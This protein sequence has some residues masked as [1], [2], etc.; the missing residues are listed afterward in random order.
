MQG[1]FESIVDFLTGRVQRLLVA[2]AALDA[3]GGS[4][5]GLVKVRIR[6]GR[7]VCGQIDGQIG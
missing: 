4:P 6:A 1:E 2:Q 5:E 3:A 7:R